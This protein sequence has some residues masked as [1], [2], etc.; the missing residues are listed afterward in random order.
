M[1]APLGRF[2]GKIGSRA[3]LSPAPVIPRR[4][5]A[6]NDRKHSQKRSQDQTGIENNPSHDLSFLDSE[7]KENVLAIEQ[8]LNHPA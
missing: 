6:E 4:H 5:L 2:I 3:A 8:E 1:D 7:G